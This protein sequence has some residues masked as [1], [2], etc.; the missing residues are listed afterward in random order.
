MVILPWWNGQPKRLAACWEALTLLLLGSVMWTRSGQEAALLKAQVAQNG[1][2]C[3]KKSSY[4]TVGRPLHENEIISWG[5]NEQLQLQGPDSQTA[6]PSRD[7]H[8][9]G[10]VGGWKSAHYTPESFND[11]KVLPLPSLTFSPTSP[12]PSSFAKPTRNTDIPPP[13]SISLLSRRRLLVLPGSRKQIPDSALILFP[14]FKALLRSAA[15]QGC[16][17]SWSGE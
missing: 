1:S 9:A 8:S 12:L 16:L 7:T 3:L 15:H 13:W 4:C 14:L 11:L 10:I 6:R 17:L 2:R 5:A